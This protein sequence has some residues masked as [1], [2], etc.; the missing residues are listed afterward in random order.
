MQNLFI[1]L[2]DRSPKYTIY[3]FYVL[4]RTNMQFK[5]F[6]LILFFFFYKRQMHELY[7]RNYWKDFTLQFFP[8]ANKLKKYFKM[9]KK[10]YIL[11][12]LQV[13]WCTFFKELHCDMKVVILKDFRNI[14]HKAAGHE[15]KGEKKSIMVLLIWTEVN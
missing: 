11:K 12:M 6:F 5:C 8:E 13:S 3:H 14:Y 10:I 9:W 1:K 7:M 2:T 15:R 4:F